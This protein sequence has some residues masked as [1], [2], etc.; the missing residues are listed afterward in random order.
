LGVSP[1]TAGALILLP[2]LAGAIAAVVDLVE[3]AVCASRTGN[4]SKFS[5]QHSIGVGFAA[6]GIGAGAAVLGALLPVG[7]AAASQFEVA[8]GSALLSGDAAAISD[9]IL[10]G[11]ACG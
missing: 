8:L 5:V 4:Y 11:G 3:Q 9:L 1:Q 6:L 2:L 10:Q 7:A